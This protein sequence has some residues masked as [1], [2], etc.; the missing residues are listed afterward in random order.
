MIKSVFYTFVQVQSYENVNGFWRLCWVQGVPLY[1]KVNTR[2]LLVLRLSVGRVMPYFC[3]TVAAQCGFAVGFES[4]RGRG[5]L[6]LVNVVFCLV[7]VFSTSWSFVQRSPTG[8]GVS[9]IVK[10]RQWGGPGPLGVVA[11]WEKIPYCPF[12]TSWCIKLLHVP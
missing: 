6:P 4:R 1:I 8:C 3:I 7:E 12:I 2:V 11:P 10:P 5:C 9:A